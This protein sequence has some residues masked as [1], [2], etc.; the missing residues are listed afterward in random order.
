M[1]P[2]NYASFEMTSDNTT[3]RLTTNT[4]HRQYSSTP[5]WSLSSPF[6]KNPAENTSTPTTAAAR[7]KKKFIPRKAAV[8]L[9]E[10]AR[11]FFKALLE[12]SPDKAGVILNYNQASSGQP[13]MVFS[14]GFVTKDQLTPDDEGYVFYIFLH[15][16]V[17]WN[18]VSSRDF[19]ECET[20]HHVSKSLYF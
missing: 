10:R 16:T 20:Q 6:S 8:T 19:S 5:Y 1:P 3:S 14:F 4:I 15:D 11:T 18:F 7:K 2:S 13:R 17:Y 12:N 9:T